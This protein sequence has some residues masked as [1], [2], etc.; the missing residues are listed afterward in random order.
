MELAKKNYI[1][2]SIDL[3]GPAFGTGSREMN[4][5]KDT[6]CLYYGEKNI[7]ASAVCT[8]KSLI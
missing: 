1:G 8:G 5:A 4:W 7:N 2:P 6:Y 3:L